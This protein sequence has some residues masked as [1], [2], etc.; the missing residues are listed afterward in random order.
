MRDRLFPAPEVAK[1]N[2][3]H[4]HDQCLNEVSFPPSSSN[5][6]TVLSFLQQFCSPSFKFPYQVSFDFQE[7]NSFRKE[8]KTHAGWKWAIENFLI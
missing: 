1:Q 4:S 2:I 3:L 5:G 8:I 6:L 7:G